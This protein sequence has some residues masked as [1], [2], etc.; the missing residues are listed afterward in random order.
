MKNLTM[1]PAFPPVNRLPRLR[2]RP[3]ILQQMARGLVLRRLESLIRG[4][5][6]IVEG[7]QIHR[8]G[9]KHASLSATIRVQ[10]SRFY[11]EIAFGGSIGAGESYMH[12][13]WS[14]DD[15]TALIRIMGLN[16]PVTDHLEGG[17]ALLARPFL[18]TLHWL[19]RNTQDGSLRNIAAHYDL[20]NAMFELFLDPTMM[21]SCA[22]FERPDLTLE[23]ASLCKLERIC[24]K[25]QL[26]ENDHVLEIGSGWGGFAIYAAR[27]HGCRITTATISKE[28]YELAVSRVSQAGLG[29][30]IEVL[31][32]DYR[33]LQSR[34]DKLVSIEMIEAVGHQFYDTYFAKCASLLKPEGMMLLQAITIADQRYE[35][36]KSSVDFIQ[37]HIFP[38][39]TIPSVTAMLQSI[40]RA[41]DLRLFDLEDIG[42]HYARTLA[43]WRRNFFRNLPRIKALGYPEEF[44]RMWEF[45]LCYCEGGFEERALGNVQMLLVKPDNRRAVT[46]RIGR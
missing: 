3:G 18:K 10:D 28:Q 27:N 12:G 46:R 4:R 17:L 9:E 45:Y 15:L 16:Q 42:P 33:N 26:G 29:D 19:N 22:V 39:S 14:C 21:Y 36:A 13:Y 24:H 7:E 30:Q 38:G 5:L 32:C 20:G 34:Y 31:L 1:K 41:S 37:R 40:T 11:G 44:I 8:F 43:E 35:A 23:Q 2:G 25:L 6:I